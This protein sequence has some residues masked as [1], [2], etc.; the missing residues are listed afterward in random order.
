MKE[1]DKKIID[2]RGK[3]ISMI[4]ISKQIGIP[5]NTVYHYYNRGLGRIPKRVKNKSD[6]EVVNTYHI[7]Y[8]N[9]TYPSYFFHL[10]SKTINIHSKNVINEGDILVFRNRDLLLKDRLPMNK[11]TVKSNYYQGCGYYEFIYEPI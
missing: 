9:K 4:D 1:I 2:M 8:D 10:T 3:G 6:K 5:R 7:M 11:N